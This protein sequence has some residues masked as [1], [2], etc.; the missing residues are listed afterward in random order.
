M[1]KFDVFKRFL[2]FNERKFFWFLFLIKRVFLVITY[3]YKRFFLLKLKYINNYF[4][5]LFKKYIKK[6]K[7]F[8]LKMDVLLTER[9]IIRLVKPHV[10][11]IAFT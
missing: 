7:H 3:K 10:R 6:Q 8:S 1:I 4:M 11:F 9:M 5:F 2:F